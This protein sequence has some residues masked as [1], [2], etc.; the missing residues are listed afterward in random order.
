MEVMARVKLARTV[1]PMDYITAAAH[2]LDGLSITSEDLDLDVHDKK[3]REASDINNAGLIEQLDYLL[4]GAAPKDIE[5]YVRRVLL[6][7]GV[8]PRL[9]NCRLQ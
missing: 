1:Q 4:A 9:S 2:Y 3:L 5:S 7:S 6:R 8:D